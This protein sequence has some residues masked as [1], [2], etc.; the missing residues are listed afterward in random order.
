MKTSAL[1]SQ[2]ALVNLSALVLVLIFARR[3]W[4]AAFGS[5]ED[6]GT[7]EAKEMASEQNPT[8]PVTHAELS[9]SRGE[10][11]QPLYIAVKNPFGDETTVFDVSSGKDFYGPGSGYHLFAGRDATY[12]LSTSCLDPAK[13]DGDISTLT[14]MEKDTHVQWYNKYSSKYPVVGFL[15]PDDYSVTNG[16]ASNSPPAPDASNNDA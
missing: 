7:S 13:L 11:G 3:L 16:D 10:E 15:V 8:R 14:A 2:S 1:R 4:Q 5:T 12:A 6:D 9:R